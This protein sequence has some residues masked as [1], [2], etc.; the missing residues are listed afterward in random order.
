MLRINSVTYKFCNYK[1]WNYKLCYWAS[2]RPVHWVWIHQQLV[3]TDIQV[4]ICTWN[5]HKQKICH[6]AAGGIRA[7]HSVFPSPSVPGQWHQLTKQ[8]RSMEPCRIQKSA[9]WQWQKTVSWLCNPKGL[10]IEVDAW[11]PLIDI[12][13]V[14]KWLMYF[15]FCGA[16]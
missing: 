16:L 4:E 2:S 5:A 13:W 15:P 7:I 11:D 6:T 9:Y 1:L 14:L 12:Y 3:S 8:Q 10:D